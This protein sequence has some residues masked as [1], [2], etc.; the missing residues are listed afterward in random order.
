M[1][2]N[3]HHDYQ[4]VKRKIL[5]AR[6]IARSMN[7]TFIVGARR[8]RKTFAQGC[9]KHISKRGV[10]CGGANACRPLR[11][12]KLAIQESGSTRSQRSSPE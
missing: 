3:K 12:L 4:T 11:P 5:N 2:I 7:C 1:S 6:H 10:H 9:R 8:R